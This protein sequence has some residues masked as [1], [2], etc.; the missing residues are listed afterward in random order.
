MSSSVRSTAKTVIISR[1][2]ANSQKI[3]YSVKYVYKISKQNKCLID[4][5]KGKGTFDSVRCCG[6]IAAWSWDFK[7]EGGNIVKWATNT[8]FIFLFCVIFN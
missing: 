8:E 6:D 2:H 4:N 3:R 5:Q 7:E 1:E